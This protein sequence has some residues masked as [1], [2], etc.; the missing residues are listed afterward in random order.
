MLLVD[1]LSGRF[2]Y[3]DRAAW[4]AEVAAGRVHRN[5]LAATPLDRLAAGDV[6]EHAPPAARASIEV[7]IVMDDTAFLAVDKP[8]HLVCHRASAFPAK[9]WGTSHTG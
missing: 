1:W 2:R 4:E 7:A 8:P 3:H 9:N 6:L 5:G